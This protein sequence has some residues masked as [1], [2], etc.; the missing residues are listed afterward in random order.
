MSNKHQNVLNDVREL[1]NTL[2]KDIN[3]VG[4]SHF[5]YFKL[6]QKRLD[7][8]LADVSVTEDDVKHS[9]EWLA[10]DGKPRQLV[11][12]RFTKLAE[13]IHTATTEKEG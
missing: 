7:A 12:K 5:E 1:L 11:C 10:R 2:E 13:L 4:E 6:V 9:Q 8:F 3:F